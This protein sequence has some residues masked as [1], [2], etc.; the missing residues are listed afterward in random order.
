V[1]SYREGKFDDVGE[2]R[3]LFVMTR[4]LKRCGFSMRVDLSEAAQGGE[5][6]IR[7][8]TVLSPILDGFWGPCVL[9]KRFCAWRL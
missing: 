6:F 5:I 3:C 7:T 1:V 9:R 2:R 4:G 8:P